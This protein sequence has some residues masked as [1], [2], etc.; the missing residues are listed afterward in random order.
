M[1]APNPVNSYVGKLT[2]LQELDQLRAAAAA[3]QAEQAEAS[4]DSHVLR[5]ATNGNVSGNV[6]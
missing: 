6:A 1:M 3:T 5:L 4:G 2:V